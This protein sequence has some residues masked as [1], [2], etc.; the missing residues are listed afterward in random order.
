MRVLAGGHFDN[1]IKERFSAI[2]FEAAQIG[3][4][5][6]CQPV[7]QSIQDTQGKTT[8]K[9]EMRAERSRRFGPIA[10]GNTY[11]FG[12]EL[13]TRNEPYV[14]YGFDSAPTAR[15]NFA[16][17]QSCADAI[18]HVEKMTDF[19][20][21][22]VGEEVEQQV[23]RLYVPEAR[24]EISFLYEFRPPR[25]RKLIDE[26]E[27]LVPLPLHDDLTPILNK[28]HQEQIRMADTVALLCDVLDPDP[29]ASHIQ[30]LL[31]A[32]ALEAFH[33]NV[34]GGEYLSKEEYEPTRKTLVGAIPASIKGDHRSSLDSRLKF[35]NELSLRTRLRQLFE[36]LDDNVFSNLNTDR[37]AFIG[38][39]VEA[40][41]D[42]THWV[43]EREQ[44]RPNG[45][46]LENL[47]KSA[48]A[49]TQ[50]IVLRHLG[51][52]VDRVVSRMKNAPWRYLRRFEPIKDS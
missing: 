8:V 18:A 16:S 28:W 31:L 15:I 52:G 50:L 32:Q 10:N 14:T 5:S 47:L 27:I 19:L 2:E 23:I 21:L 39:L 1:E 17:P 29:P 41:N 4:W 46:H 35:G 20:T 37:K 36:P 3:P 33:R 38:D 30:L 44:A 24:S 7:E 40:R 45:A 48:L 9:F 34:I 12:S 42:F 6:T 49:L 22:M 43:Q 26:Q 11:E 51:V 25:Q 13:K